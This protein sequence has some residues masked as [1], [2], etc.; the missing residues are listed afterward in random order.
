MYYKNLGNYFDEVVN[1]NKKRI[2]IDLT[3][4]KISFTKLKLES[5][6]IVNYFIINNIGIN[7]SICICLKKN[8]SS[9]AIIIACL[10]LGINYSYLDRLSPK[11]RLNKIINI[12]NPK[13]IITDDNLKLKTKYKQVKLNNLNIKKKSNNIFCNI[14]SFEPNGNTVAYTMFT[15]GSTGEPKGVAINHSQLLNF[16]M[17]SKKKFLIGENSISTNLNPLFFDNSIFDI[18]GCLFNGSTMVSF[19]RNEILNGTELLKKVFLKKINIWFSVPSLLI[20]YLNLNLLTKKK[21]KNLKKIIFGGEGF[22]KQ[23]LLKLFK[24]KSK[25]SELINV[26]GPTECTCICSA[27]KITKFDFQKTEMTKFAPLGKKLIENFFYKIVNSKNQEVKLG[28]SGE[29]V[30]GGP[31]VGCGY[32]GNKIETDKKFIQNPSH[33]NYRDI[34]YLSGDIVKQDKKTNYIYFLSRKDRQIKFMG[35]RIELDEIE[36]VIN[37][38]KDVKQNVTCFGKK[39]GRYEI[40]SWVEHK[41]SLNKIISNLKLILPSYMIPKKII[42]LKKLPKN[43]NGK[44][45]RIALEKQYYD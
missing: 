21:I 16:T 25:K 35:H 20:Y 39:N 12:I 33:S 2:A 30:I 14:E 26:Y 31:N 32:F 34:M 7:D 17:W 23:S 11:K 43:N 4:K 18:Y 44:L 10:K 41:T 1:K 9:F 8:I 24:L 3:D 27:Y 5:N 6:K 29:L 36:L 13:I 22:P 38:I 45:D 37:K 19:H 28:N 42:E 40:V 15:S